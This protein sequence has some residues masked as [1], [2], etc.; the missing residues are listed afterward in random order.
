M[1]GTQWPIRH[2]LEEH[3]LGENFLDA[4]NAMLESQ[5]CIMHGGT[6]VDA[7]IIRAPI[8]TKNATGERDTEM[9]P[10]KKGNE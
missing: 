6:I 10:M 1:E 9:H 8:S 7:T 4:V 3:E 2:L 5:G